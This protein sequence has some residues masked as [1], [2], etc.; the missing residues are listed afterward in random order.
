MLPLLGGLSIDRLTYK[1]N[2]IYRKETSKR[3]SKN[4]KL[5]NLITE[6]IYDYFVRIISIQNAYLFLL[7]F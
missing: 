6:L 4:R 2:L 5:I 1:N 3:P 7:F